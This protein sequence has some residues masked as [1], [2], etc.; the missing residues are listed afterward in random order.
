MTTLDATAAR[1]PW[2]ATTP[3]PIT[4]IDAATEIDGARAI[5]AMESNSTPA[6]R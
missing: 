5:A 6:G 2:D 4:G 3:D 1:L